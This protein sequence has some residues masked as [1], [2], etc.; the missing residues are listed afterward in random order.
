M[1]SAVSS[2]CS[3]FVSVVVPV[4]NGAGLIERALASLRRQTLTAWEA[5]IVDDASTDGTATVAEQLAAHDPRVRVIRRPTNGGVSAARNVALARA[6]GDWVAYLDQDDEFY[7]DYLEQIRTH[8]AGEADV[9]VFRY[10]LLEERLG[11]PRYGHTYTHDPAQVH[12]RLFRE[13]IAVPLGVAHRRKVTDHTDGFDERLPREQDSEL[14]RRFATAGAVF[15]FRPEKSGLYHIRAEGA[16]RAGPRIRR[17]RADPRRPASRGA[18]RY[19]YLTNP[20]LQ[21]LRC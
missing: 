15:T 7:P 13:H 1:N 14:W 10:D 12:D 3:P 5:L 16:S 2:G 8:A 11:H 20:H 17:C 18:N 6:R 4:F 21:P 19:P 9:L